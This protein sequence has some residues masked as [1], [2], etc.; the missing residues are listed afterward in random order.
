MLITGTGITDFTAK[1]L[2]DFRPVTT[3]AIKWRQL[4]SGNWAG[5]DRGAAQDQYEARFSIYGTEATINNFITQ[6]NNSR[7]NGD[8]TITLSTFTATEYIFGE[9]VNHTSSALTATVLSMP[10]RSQRT[11]KGFTVADIHIRLTSTVAFTGT[12][13][14][15]NLKWLDHGATADAD[16]LVSKPDTYNGTVSYLDHR[17]DAGIFDGV[18]TMPNVSFT[19]L[20]NYIKDQRTA[21]LSLPDT[22][23][24][25]Y[26]FGPRSTGSYPFSVKLLEW[27][28]LGWFGTIYNRI[29]LKFAEVI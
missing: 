3:L 5:L 7:V 11:W 1:I 12:S 28:D 2:P 10:Q 8:N 4:A 18:F 23:G 19:R 26:P 6:I 25:T 13:V 21:T 20:R 14:L 29:R 9:N 17:S 27:E 22:F 15:E 16:F 24:V